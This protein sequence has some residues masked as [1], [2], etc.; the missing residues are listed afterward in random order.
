MMAVDSCVPTPSWSPTNTISA[1]TSTLNTKE[2]T[3][4]FESKIWSR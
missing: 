3:N 4:T 2:T 1:A